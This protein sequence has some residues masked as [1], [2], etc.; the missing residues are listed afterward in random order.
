MSGNLTSRSR[1]ARFG[2]AFLLAVC[3]GALGANS[4]LANDTRTDSNSSA[5]Q[6]GRIEVAGPS[7]W[8]YGTHHLVNDDGSL[9]RVYQE[10]VP[11]ID[12]DKYLKAPRVVACSIQIEKPPVPGPNLYYVYSISEF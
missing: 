10:R 7:W 12:L 4:A 11:G 9:I 3:V 6:V 1:L 8:M 5:C 2:A